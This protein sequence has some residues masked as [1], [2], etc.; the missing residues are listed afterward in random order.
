MTKDLKERRIKALTG[1]FDRAI[2]TMIANANAAGWSADE[3]LGAIDCVVAQLKMHNAIDPD[4]ADDPDIDR[5]VDQ[6][7]DL[8]AADPVQADLRSISDQEAELGQEEREDLPVS[9]DEIL[10][11][12][13]PDSPRR[14]AEQ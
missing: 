6:E 7:I 3:A 14:M 13:E 10:P 2:Q 12:I 9:A 8:Q 11:H 1:A 4:P 5:D